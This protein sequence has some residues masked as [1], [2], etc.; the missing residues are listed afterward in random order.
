M[1][2]INSNHK[3][4]IM[5]KLSE[6]RYEIQSYIKTSDFMMKEEI[7]EKYNLTQE[8]L[9]ELNKA[10]LLVKIY[11]ELNMCYKYPVFQFDKQ[12]N[13]VKIYKLKQDNFSDTAIIMF[14]K[15]YNK[16][17]FVQDCFSFNKDFCL[18]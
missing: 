18:V 7:F 10:G 9:V 6:Q 17:E 13:L 12:D 11:D 8:H 1:R 2:T 3:D 16:N 14:F 15:K 5:K 4:E